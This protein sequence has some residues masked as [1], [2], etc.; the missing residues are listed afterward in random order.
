M[1]LNWS[2]S[3]VR[4]TSLLN[5]VQYDST[6]KVPRYQ[7]LRKERQLK[8]TKGY[9]R[10]FLSPDRTVEERIIWQK[11]VSELK[12]K[13]PADPKKYLIIGKDEEWCLGETQG[14][15]VIV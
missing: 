1:L 10:V 9:E 14:C 15:I 7:I 11:L 2:D 12:K 8:D 4:S 6:S 5:Q 3:E 13:K